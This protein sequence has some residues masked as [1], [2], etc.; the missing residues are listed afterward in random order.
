VWELGPPHIDLLP[1]H[2]NENNENGKS[3]IGTGTIY[4]EVAAFYVV[5]LLKTSNL[6]TMVYALSKFITIPSVSSDPL[7]KEDCRQAGIWL[8]KCLG[9]LGAHTA[10][11]CCIVLVEYSSTSLHSCQLAKAKGIILL[12]SQLS[13][14]PHTRSADIA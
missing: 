5:C 3:C 13:K 1:S 8:K 14:V 11:V 2:D 6:D 7:R 9:Q 4:G 10:L 12:C